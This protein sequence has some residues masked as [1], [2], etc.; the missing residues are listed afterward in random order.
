M[1]KNRDLLTSSLKILRIFCEG[2]NI[3]RLSLVISN[4]RLFSICSK[5]KQQHG[6]DVSVSGFEV[7]CDFLYFSTNLAH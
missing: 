6:V 5:H 4:I 7:L 3:A 2:L 1:E